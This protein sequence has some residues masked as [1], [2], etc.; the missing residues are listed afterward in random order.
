MSKGII[1]FLTFLRLFSWVLGVLGGFTV[2]VTVK[3]A[4]QLYSDY[5]LI[6]YLGRVGLFVM[7][8]FLFFVA[9]WV[10]RWWANK[11]HMARV[12]ADPTEA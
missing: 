1:V 5:G 2:F 11:L 12:P 6:E 4:F 8:A 9:A 3:A 10:V 7:A